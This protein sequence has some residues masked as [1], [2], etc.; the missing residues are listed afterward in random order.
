MVPP[1]WS[2]PTLRLRQQLRCM[3]I[4][5]FLKVNVKRRSPSKGADICSQMSNFFLFRVNPY[6]R[7]QNENGLVSFPESALAVTGHP[8]A[9]NLIEKERQLGVAD[10]CIIL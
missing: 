7:R 9:Y 5:P 2:E 1:F 3:G 8:K 4:S 10:Y 6:L